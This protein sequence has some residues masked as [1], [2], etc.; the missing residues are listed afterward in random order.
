MS[1]E[2]SSSKNE[3]LPH[4]ETEEEQETKKAWGMLLPCDENLPHVSLSEPEFTMGRS[5]RCTFRLSHT[6]IS[7]VHLKI[8]LQELKG[9]SLV[10]VVD[11]SSNGTYLNEV[12]V[13]IFH[14]LTFFSY[15]NYCFS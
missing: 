8:S 2:N 14:L 12:K 6:H 5:T 10:N 13:T 4:P 7:G 9:I 11:H 1:E 15:C 3:V